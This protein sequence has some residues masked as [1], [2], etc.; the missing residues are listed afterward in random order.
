MQA[1]ADSLWDSV[2]SSTVSDIN[3]SGPWHRWVLVD[4][5]VNAALVFINAVFGN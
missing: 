5:G 3:A 4:S 1:F 2:R